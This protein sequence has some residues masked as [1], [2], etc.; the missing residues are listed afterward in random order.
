[1]SYKG[2]KITDDIVAKGTLAP[3]PAVAAGTPQRVHDVLLFSGRAERNSH[4]KFSQAVE[5]LMRVAA[6]STLLTD[7]LTVVAGQMYGAADPLETDPTAA[8][9]LPERRFVT[10]IFAGRA[11]PRPQFSALGE[12]VDGPAS[13]FVADNPV[14]D[15]T[16][17]DPTFELATTLM[18]E[19]T[20]AAL[21]RVY[22][23]GGEPWAEPVKLSA[24]AAE[25]RRA[26]QNALRPAFNAVTAGPVDTAT[27]YDPDLKVKLAKIAKNFLAHNVS[28]AAMARECVPYLVEALFSEGYLLAK[29]GSVRRWFGDAL[30]D[31]VAKHV[32]PDIA[33]AARRTREARVVG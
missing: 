16:S 4:F 19:Y 15:Q 21:M 1:M 25:T 27:P 12:T 11:L 9:W 8:P 28:Q 13:V 14:D 33:A 32:E 5:Q 22:R 10:V 29:Q 6:T 23:N 7:I 26:A 31:A 17:G 18:H 20:H 24:Q 3:L 30:P 2:G